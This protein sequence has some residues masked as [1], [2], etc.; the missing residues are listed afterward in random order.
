VFNPVSTL[1]GATLR[2]IFGDGDTAKLVEGLMCGVEQ[3][4][5]EVG[6]SA[7]VLHVVLRLNPKNFV[8]FEPPD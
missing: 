8:E 6:A 7:L 5:K 1:T 4:A 3:V 2:A